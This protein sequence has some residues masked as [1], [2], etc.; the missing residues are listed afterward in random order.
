MSLIVGKIKRGFKFIWQIFLMKV[1]FEISFRLNMPSLSANIICL[2]IKTLNRSHKYRVLC[3]GR[4]QFYD[5]VRGLITYGDKIQYMYFHKIL[6][7]RI[8]R[9][10]I[11]FNLDLSL[12]PKFSKQKNIVASNYSEDGL[13]YHI[14]PRYS[15][16]KR[17]V[18]NY[19]SKMFPILHKKLKFDAVMSGNY[20]YIDQQ[21]F[22]KICEENDVPVIILNKEGVGGKN[23][24][25]E[26][27]WSA[28]GCR[29]IGSKMLFMN[30]PYMQSEIKHLKG[31]DKTKAS[32]VGLPRFDFYANSPLTQSKNI[33]LFAFL[34]S[35]YFVQGLTEKEMTILEMITDEFHKNFI[36]FAIKHP[37]Y[38]LVIKTKPA[39]R[40]LKQPKDIIN[41]YFKEFKID[42]LT[43]TNDAKVENLIINASVILGYNTTALI[44]GLVA[45]KTIVSP[46]FSAVTGSNNKG[47]FKDYSDL[48]N[49]VNKYDEMENIILNYNDFA[50]SDLNRKKQF[51]EP[52]IYKNDGKVSQRAERDIIKT[53]VERRGK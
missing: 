51:F 26:G 32:L 53:I 40:Y 37:E 22:F 35:D 19:M 1:L 4:S 36:T 33:V 3:L 14:D 29:F 41:K 42:N 46:N 30:N 21:E 23:I 34:I 13:T 9:Y 18:Y 15:E 24:S 11:P 48:L 45:N 28:W 31:L 8:V 47:L 49:Y 6:L 39:N 43:I 38:N 10:M 20:V 5:D 52:L 12:L 7:G 44:E 2:L 17:K 27:S 50:C 16:G 25:S